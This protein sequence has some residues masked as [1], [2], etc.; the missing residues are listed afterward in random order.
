M[1]STGVLNNNHQT[2]FLNFF[3]SNRHT[4]LFLNRHTGAPVEVPPVL[5]TQLKLM[6]VFLLY[7]TDLDPVIYLLFNV[8][9]NLDQSYISS[10]GLKDFASY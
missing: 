4:F 6:I 8:S 5:K 10:E 7:V 2:Y 9:L 3:L 1:E